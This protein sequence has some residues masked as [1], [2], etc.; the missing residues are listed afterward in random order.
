MSPRKK[1]PA[2]PTQWPIRGSERCKRTPRPKRR[3]GRKSRVPRVALAWAAERD[4]KTVCACDCGLPIRVKWF[5]R[6]GRGLPRFIQGHQRRGVETAAGRWVRENQGKHFCQCGC[7]GAI[8]IRIHHHSYGVPRFLRY[9][10]PGSRGLYGAANARYKGGRTKT[11]QGYINVLVGSK[12][13]GRSA[14]ALEHRLVME[15]ALGRKLRRNESVHHKNGRRT[16]NRLC[17]LELWRRGQPAGQRVQD[18]L[19]FAVSVIRDHAGDPSVWPE[20]E[21]EVLRR[22]TQTMKKYDV[23]NGSK[24][25]ASVAA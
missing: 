1:S 4:R 6:Y 9:H 22:I 13:G 23:Q 18:M 20:G 24:S 2:G 25:A 17:N 8:T 14:Y 10:W 7:G 15:R 11:T 5:H 19:S 21:T 3:S 16:D 12:D